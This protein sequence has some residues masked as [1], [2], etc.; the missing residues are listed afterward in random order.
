VTYERELELTVARLRQ[1]P[2]SRLLPAEELVYDVLG[3][4]TSREV[5]RLRATVWGD[6]VLVIGRLVP[7]QS[8]PGLVEALRQLRR[9]F[10]LTLG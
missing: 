3:Q 4:M 5:P 9:R 7:S 10:D 2:V 6:Q 1:L 8:R